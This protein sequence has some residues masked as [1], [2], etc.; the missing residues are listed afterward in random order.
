ML[1][2]RRPRA[3]SFLTNT[4]YWDW[5]QP[6]LSTA[7]AADTK[8][9]LARPVAPGFDA[10]GFVSYFA[11]CIMHDNPPEHARYTIQPF[12]TCPVVHT[13]TS[14]PLTTGCT[15]APHHASAEY[16]RWIDRGG[17]WFQHRLTCRAR[18]CVLTA[19]RFSQFRAQ[20][21]FTGTPP[22]L[23]INLGSRVILF[24]LHRV[25]RSIFTHPS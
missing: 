3:L 6:R 16:V 18:N 20:A 9:W 23:S 17:A 10:V 5:T 12:W 24:F 19:S 1:S 15:H 21:I 25:C 22:R 14:A 8:L 4:S 13:I 2:C 7:C 11:L